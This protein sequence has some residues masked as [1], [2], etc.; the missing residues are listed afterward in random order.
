VGGVDGTWR[1]QDLAGTWFDGDV[2]ARHRGDACSRRGSISI[3]HRDE[4]TTKVSVEELDH[5]EEDEKDSSD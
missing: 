4:P 1:G 5:G 2:A 3:G